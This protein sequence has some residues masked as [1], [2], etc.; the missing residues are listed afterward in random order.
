MKMPV[1]NA[2]ASIY[3]TT[4]H[5]RLA[6][7]GR[8]GFVNHVES[9]QLLPRPLPLPDG[10][11]NG[12]GCDCKPHIGPC[13]V[14]PTNCPETGHSRT[15]LGCDCSIDVICCTPPCLTTC[16]PC[17]GGSCNPYPNCGPVPGSGTQTCTDCHGNVSTRAC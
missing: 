14:D 6:W 16:G 9:A 2:Q 7:T 15:V 12:G 13:K 1:F 10:L 8:R 5:Y 3:M 17:T 11:P 4:V